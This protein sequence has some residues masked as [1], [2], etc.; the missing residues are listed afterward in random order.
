MTCLLCGCDP[1][2]DRSK[3]DPDRL[4]FNYEVVYDDGTI[5]H[6]CLGCYEY[7]LKEAQS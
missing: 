5:I 6:V 4:F 1:F 7:K 2:G 3:N